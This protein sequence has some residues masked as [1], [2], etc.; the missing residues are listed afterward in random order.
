MYLSI[1]QHDLF[2]TLLMGFEIPFRLYV[3]DTVLRRFPTKED[4]KNELAARKDSLTPSAPDSLKNQLPRYCTGTKGDKL[5]QKLTVANGHRDSDVV[6]SDFDVPTVGEL[7][8]ITFALANEFSDL[9]LIFN[10]YDGYCLLAEKWRYARNKLQHPGCKTLEDHDLLP[11]LTFVK[12]ILTDLDSS[13]FPQKSREDLLV[14][15]SV[16]QNRKMEI[17]FRVHNFQNL[18]D[19]ESK[20][21]CRESEIEQLKRFICG[22]PGDLRK[23]HS[24]CIYGYGG[25]G[26]TALALEVVKRIIQDIWDNNSRNEYRPEYILFYSAKS[27]KLDIADA[28]GKMIVR[29]VRS[30]FESAEELKEMILDA[31]GIDSFKNFH[32]EG[33]IIVDNLESLSEGER[34]KIKNLIE[35]QTPPEMQFLITSRNSEDYEMNF[36]LSGFDYE[37]GSEFVDQYIS[38]NGLELE[39]SQDEVQEL[40]SLSKG[41]TLLLVLCLRR[42][43]RHLTTLNGLSSEFSSTK[44][45]GNIRNHLGKYP[46][47]AYETVSEFM[48]KDT[49]EEI[50]QV[51]CENIDLFHEILMIFAVCREGGI[52][53]NT[54]CIL[55]KKTYDKVEAVADTLCN[56]LILEKNAELYVLNEFAEKYIVDRFMPNAA[57]YNQLESEIRHRQHQVERELEK[58]NSEIK[59][60]PEL[61]KILSDWCVIYPSDRIAAANMYT[62]YG[63]AD[64]ACKSDSKYKAEAALEDVIKTSNEAEQITAHPYIKFQKARILHL[65]DRSRILQEIHTEEIINSY[66]NAIFVIKTIDQFAPI[67]NTKS[68]AS[69]LWLFGQ[70]L[71]DV[72]QKERAVRYLEEAVETFQV[73]EIVDK[74]YFQCLSKL[75]FVCID[76]YE[77]N[78]AERRKYLNIAR[79]VNQKLQ[80]QYNKLG[81]Q[82][83]YANIFKQRLQPYR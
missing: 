7:N 74:E 21:V 57:V 69:L 31:N 48:F 1:K 50:E 66:A 4:F 61:R 77:E 54:I 23:R 32:R 27:S 71:S 51:F 5:Y 67:Q 41:N 2:R 53:L 42:L 17:P 9:Y 44:A 38:E 15:V 70:Y 79:E 63:D 36:K 30:H 37:S 76:Y 24:C 12:D 80:N 35:L 78:F 20:I 40:L 3:A 58:L 45:W 25:V 29:S 14:E 18:P 47:N 83:R 13:Y 75:G 34:A 65:I 52:D 82:K 81:D 43:S 68:Y 16:L 59:R 8:V 19:S 6:E 64:R 33:L 26:K 28:N 22:N 72:N 55:S 56:Y 49:F 11:V 73:L 39:L 46:G 62:L 60:R 10:G